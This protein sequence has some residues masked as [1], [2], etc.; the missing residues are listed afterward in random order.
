MASAMC[1]SRMSAAPAYN[2]SGQLQYVTYAYDVLGNLTGRHDSSD[3]NLNIDLNETFHYDDLNRLEQVLLSL[4]GETPTEKLSVAYD[5][6][7][8]ISNKSDVGTYLYN[9]P[10]PHA[11]SGILNGTSYNYDANGNQTSGD[12]RTITYSVFDKPTSISKGNSQV[13]FFYGIG[14][15]RYR[16][17]D[18]EGGVL[19]KTTLYLGSVERISENGSTYYKRYLGGVAIATYYP[20]TGVEQL[21]Y[22]LKDHLGSIHTVIDANGN[23]TRMHFDA[24]GRR[25]DM[26]WQS[27]LTY[28]ANLNDIT[29]RGYTGHEQVDAMGIIH[30]NGRIY[31]PKLGRFL[32]ADP[33]VQAPKNSQNLNRY[34]YVLN[35]PLSY[36]DP[37]GNSF[38]KSIRSFVSIGVLFIPGVNPY[39]LGALSGFVV[40]GN[41]RGA[42]VGA[43]T[44]GLGGGN[45]KGVEGFFRNGIIG[46]LSSRL[47]GGSFKN[48]FISAG[49][50]SLAGGPISRLKY[51]TDRVMTRAIVGGT[52]SRVTGGKFANGAFSA[53]FAQSLAETRPSPLAFTSG[54]DTT[55]ARIAHAVET[56]DFSDIDGFSLASDEVAQ[57]AGL[58]GALI[59]EKSGLRAALLVKGD[60]YVLAFAGTDVLSLRD[61][62]TDLFQAFGLPTAQYATA[63]KYAQSAALRFGSNL[64]FTGHSLGGGL[65]S[66]A[67]IRT[68]LHATTFNAAGLSSQTASRYNRTLNNSSVLIHAYYSSY[69]VL[70]LLQDYSPLPNAAGQRISLGTA[71]YHHIADLCKRSGGC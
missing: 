70:S 57:E 50:S 65:A 41:I 58:P 15:T 3:I 18:W 16:R 31:D 48:G 33:V 45:L 35:N 71:G 52:L 14:N 25:Q 2:A 64:R 7:G 56:G 21:A 12:G 54:D 9:G 5:A 23:V 29:T 39:V 60:Q 26:Y 17:D 68:G 13:N 51:A 28:F 49:F 37:T 11:V 32:Q 24:F 46:G 8:N 38:W 19:Q 20:A 53:A 59:S 40:T 1:R 36:T 69:D 47:I 27:P 62:T 30:M 22:L 4:N 55:D 61:W 66:L 67:A 6:V 42:L 63:A 10:H 43:F 34:S 44:A